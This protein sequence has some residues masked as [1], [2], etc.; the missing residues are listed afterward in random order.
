M[1]AMSELEK[2]SPPQTSSFVGGERPL[3]LLTSPGLGECG[4]GGCRRCVSCRPWSSVSPLPPTASSV[5]HGSQSLTPSRGGL[6]HSTAGALLLKVK[7]R[8]SSLVRT[9]FL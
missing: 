9:S 7:Q 8:D 3:L 5:D 4:V 2:H 6:Y 1:N